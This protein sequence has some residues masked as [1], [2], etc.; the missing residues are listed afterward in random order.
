MRTPPKRPRLTPTVETLESRELLSAAPTP[1]AVLWQQNFDRTAAGAL[2]S[3]WSQWTSQAAFGVAPTPGSD[4]TAGLAA[5]GDRGQTAR[6]WANAAQPADIRASADIFVNNLV[7]AQLFVRGSNLNTS[8]PTYYAVSVTRG[9]DVTLTSTVNG[10]TRTLAHVKTAGYLS[11]VWLTISLQARGTSLQIMVRRRDNGQYLTPQGKWQTRSV[12]ALSVTNSAIRGGGLVGVARAAGVTGDVTFDNFLVH[13]AN[14]SDSATPRLRQNFDGITRGQLP[15]GWSAWQSEGAFGASSARS[16]SRPNGLTNALAGSSANNATILAWANA[17]APAN[18]Q[19]SADV[20]LNNMAPAEVFLRGSGLNSGSPSYYAVAVTRGMEADLLRVQHGKVTTL[21]QVLSNSYL[22]GQWVRVSLEASGSKLTAMIE[23]LDTNRYLTAD[24]DWQASPAAALTV[25]DRSLAGGGQAGVGKGSGSADA[26]TFDDVALSGPSASPLAVAI[27]GVSAGDLVTRATTV[28]AQVSNATHLQKVEFF[29]DGALRATD[30]RSPY[31][32]SLDPNALGDGTHTLTVIAYEQGGA[33]ARASMDV[34]TQSSGPQIPQHYPWIRIAELAFSGMTLGPFERQLLRTSV[35]LIIP[36]VNLLPQLNASV[37]D[38][39][40]LIYTNVST[41]YQDLL[42]NWLNWADAHHVSRELA[43]YHVTRPTP[44]SGNSASALQVDW[45]WSVLAGGGQANFIDLTSPAHSPGGR[46]VPFGGAGTSIYMGYPDQFREINFNLASGARNGWS[47][48]LEYP[49]AVDANGVPTAWATLRTLTDT[50]RGLTR[51]GQITFDPPA[52][53][54]PA[55]LNGPPRLYYVRIRTVNDGT[56][57]VASTIL[58]R[59]YT[60]SRGGWRG[61]TPVFD[62][63]ADRNHDGYLNNAEYAVALKAGDTARFAYESRLLTLSY[64]P[65]RP[66]TN[67]SS[68][69]FQSWAV[70]YSLS[71][72]QGQP[73]SDGLFVDNSSGKPPT[74][75]GVVEPLDTYAADYGRLLADIGRA[76]APRWIL[77]N[78]SGGQT[79][80]DSVISQ[81]TGYFEESAL[82]PLSSNWAE[83]EDMASLI[84]HRASLR[85]PSPYAVLDTLATGGSPTDPRTQLAALAEYYLVADP[86]HTFLDF[87]GGQEPATSWTR[88][89]SQAVT[90]DVG[91]PIGGYSLF[92]SGTDPET[93]YLTYHVYSRQYTNALVLYR[94]LSRAL[95]SRANGKLDSSSAVLLRLNGTYR[96]L[97]ANGIL[98]RVVTS[99]SLRNGEGAILVPVSGTD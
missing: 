89:W 16:H 59:D 97:N 36:N 77:A 51:S 1:A 99:V 96:P 11:N 78:T 84:A 40:Q 27:Q 67:P 5:T 68:A 80:A 25:T 7:P 62:Y 54:V 26:V 48:V 44:F 74:N 70:Q 28:R 13:G 20:F 55:V 49:T 29:L 50:T 60:N 9:L 18:A 21:G 73:L 41:L 75:D 61:T 42:T 83:F 86:T 65:M 12:A 6:A 24:G 10:T 43:F 32:W 31:T 38:T 22:S 57:P 91:Q 98:G 46:S 58:G 39:P 4:R 30:T 93:R 15:A 71:V 64:G 66:V 45:F 19:V 88:H 63:A 79:V 76:I 81:N 90:F 34:H 23:R 17:A 33:T 2:P 94:P 52:N 85:S 53:W 72:L 47:E 3:G 82:R 56:A 14:D 92:A 69:A 37:P 8:A 35:D 87:F 95:G